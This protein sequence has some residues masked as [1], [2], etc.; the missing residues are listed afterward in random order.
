M[1]R[2]LRVRQK[3]VFLK[4]KRVVQVKALRPNCLDGEICDQA[5]FQ[6]STLLHNRK[7]KFKILP[8]KQKL[9]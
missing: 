6:T 8:F 3:M 7:R 9:M 5:K 4:K 1:L 2:K